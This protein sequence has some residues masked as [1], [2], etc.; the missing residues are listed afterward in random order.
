MNNMAA[1]LLDGAVDLHCHPGP[2]PF[3]RRIGIAE[4]AAQ[5]ASAGF[6]AIVVKSHHHSMV[7]DVLALRDAD[8]LTIPVYSGVALNNY[9]GDINPHA[10]DLCLKL[11]GRIVWFPTISSPKHIAEHEGLKFPTSTQPLLPVRPIRIRD[12]D[13]ALLPQVYEVLEVIRDQ[14]AVLAGGHLDVG[15]LDALVRAA[16]DLGIGRILIQHPNFVVGAT[17]DRCVRWAEMG[18][19]IEHSLCMYDD[20]S[21]FYHWEIGQLLEYLR[22]V[23]P[24]RTALV[25]DL[26]QA[27]NPLPVESYERILTSLAKEGVDDKDLRAMVSTTPSRVLDL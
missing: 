11:G 2:S 24:D 15:D 8:A 10:V 13:G 3:P 25:S 18:A 16:H 7:T 12:K 23:G 19:V 5:A 22:A 26:G 4:A 14:D 20:R 17:P 21:T 6:R 27:N 9:V 1:E